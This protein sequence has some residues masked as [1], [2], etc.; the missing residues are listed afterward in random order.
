MASAQKY[1]SIL[2]SFI[3]SCHFLQSSIFFF[4]HSILLWSSCIWKI[5]WDPFFIKDS[6]EW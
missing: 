2:D 1:F 4:Q 6:F 5:M 3:S